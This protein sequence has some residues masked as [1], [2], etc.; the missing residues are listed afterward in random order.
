MNGLVS[1]IIPT[2]KRSVELKRAID[3]VLKQTYKNIE[4]II[5]D[6]NGPG[7]KWN[8]TVK[9]IMSEYSCMENIK[10]IVNEK[11]MG[12][13]A[14]RNIGIENARGEYIAFLDD[15]D[16]YYEEKISKQVKLFENSLDESIALVYC[17]TESYDE[18]NNKIQEYKYDYVGNC[19]FEAMCGCIASTSQ[20][21]CKAKYLNEVG[22]FTDV[23]S[24]Q[25][26]T[27][28]IKLLNSGFKVD[29][30]PEILV[31]YNEHSNERISSGGLKNIEGEKLLRDFCRSIYN[32]LN[33][34]EITKIEGEFSFRLA[35]LYIRN[36]MYNEAKKEFKNILNIDIYKYLKIKLY[37]II[38]KLNLNKSTDI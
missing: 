27:V 25:D 17:Y 37:Y 35:K 2:Y 3:S 7:T 30:V 4:I 14:T 26:S 16:E 10:Y 11:N 38:N 1:I 19:L 32:K 18:N 20:W 22:N 24:K 36:S 9:K 8:E 6:D 29:R 12:G 15:D 21:L 28:I 31:R 34:K 33:K 23:P 13:A 5:I